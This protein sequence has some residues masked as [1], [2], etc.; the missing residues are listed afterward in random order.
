MDSECVCVYMRMSCVNVREKRKDSCNKNAITG[1]GSRY[2]SGPLSFQRIYDFKSS[3]PGNKRNILF[4]R[5]I[6]CLLLNTPLVYENGFPFSHLRRLL[7]NFIENLI[8]RAINNTKHFQNAQS[9]YIYRVRLYAQ[10]FGFTQI[11]QNIKWRWS[12]A[13]LITMKKKIKYWTPSIKCSL[14]RRIFN[15]AIIK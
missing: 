5:I 6:Y 8:A 7:C 2:R 13:A 9:F 4:T 15:P 12:L 3:P 1:P 10:C 11:M 14:A